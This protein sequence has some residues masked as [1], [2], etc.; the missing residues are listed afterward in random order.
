MEPSSKIPAEGRDSDA[1]SAPV[2]PP[3][4]AIPDRVDPDVAAEDVTVVD[5]QPP[6]EVPPAEPV[7]A[8]TSEYV[9]EVEPAPSRLQ[10]E[11]AAPPAPVAADLGAVDEPVRQPGAPTNLDLP[12]LDLPYPAPPSRPAPPA[13]PA[14][15]SGPY[16]TPGGYAENLARQS[17]GEPAP[18]PHQAPASPAPG[19]AY[20]DPA[21]SQPQY[22]QQSAY[23]QQPYAQQPYAQQSYGQL[24]PSGVL[25]PTEEST[26]ATAAH[27]SAILAS[28]VGLGFLGPLIIMLTQGQK[29]ARVRANAVES[30]NFE[31]TFVLAMIVSGILTLLLV[32]LIGLIGLPIVWL[33]LRIIASVQT[34]SGRDY[35]YPA[36]LRLVK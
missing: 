35:R 20:A 12:S 27:W 34:S 32:G 3:I 33:I 6:A 14:A 25:N 18:Q 21:W 31:I 4:A 9:P 19:S 5:G 28:F 11:D 10:L 36:T 13:P 16:V 8:P 15:P 26:W 1:V 24:V 23:G 17:Y 30:L 29:S 22:G 2:D 7:A